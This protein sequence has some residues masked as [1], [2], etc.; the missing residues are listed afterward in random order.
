MKWV[1][2]EVVV[3][4]SVLLK[5]LEILLVVSQG[6]SSQHHLLFQR[7]AMTLEIQRAEEPS[8]KP[9]NNRGRKHKI[10][11]KSY[12]TAPFEMQIAFRERTR[13][14]IRYRNHKKIHE[15][16]KITSMNQP[17]RMVSKPN[18][19]TNP[20]NEN[21]NPHLNLCITNQKAIYIC[22]CNFIT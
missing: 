4:K 22:M 1:V 19:R 9:T 5:V 21:P 17:P 11:N 14:R 15:N 6:I 7:P 3:T 18:I 16:T 20:T 10:R 8:E 13:C 2:K 12:P